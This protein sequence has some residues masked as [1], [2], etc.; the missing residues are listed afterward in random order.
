MNVSATAGQPLPGVKNLI[1]VGSG[2]GGVGKSTVSVNLAVA[3][4]GL[5]HR[6]GLLDA[7]VFGPNAPRMLGSD[8]APVGKGDTIQPVEACGLQFMSFGLLN[9]GDEATVWRGPMLHGVIRQFLHNVAWTDL[10]Y[11]VVDLP[12]G[13]GDVQISLMQSA[14]VTGS[15]IVT[16]PSE[17]SLEDARKAVHMFRKM[18]TPILGVVENM[19]FLE[20]P[21]GGRMDVFGEGGGRRMAEAMGIPYLAEIPLVPKIRIAG[22]IG[23]PASL[24]PNGIGAPFFALA[25]KVVEAV[26]TANLPRPKITIEN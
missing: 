16:T 26:A 10:D 1:A 24:D 6:A 17:V 18:N 21:D 15:V 19:S 4:A 9:R 22:D 20:L 2:K 14:A 13:T 25:R 11:L 5:G 23:H 3:L 8:Q 12:P 7:D